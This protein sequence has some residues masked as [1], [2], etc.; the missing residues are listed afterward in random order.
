M[1][2]GH[3]IKHRHTAAHN[4]SRESGGG[5][6]DGGVGH[7]LA[8]PY[9]GS[10]IADTAAPVVCVTQVYPHTGVSTHRCVLRF[11]SRGS[12]Q[13]YPRS[14]YPCHTRLSARIHTHTRILYIFKK[15][16]SMF[17]FHICARRSPLHA[18]GSGGPC[19]G[20]EAVHQPRLKLR[21]RPRLD[22]DRSSR[23]RG[24]GT[25]SDKT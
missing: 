21:L 11:N 1:T 17:C 3:T 18:T 25:I 7:L 5:P 12:I 10:S 15:T 14:K 13:V 16:S 19:A 2:R 24:Q 9:S 20:S 22:R 8:G 6:G 4:Q 23:V